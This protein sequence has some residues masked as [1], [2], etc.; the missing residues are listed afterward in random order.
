MIPI[1]KNNIEVFPI[2]VPVNNKLKSVN[3]FLVKQ[4]NSLTLID[5]GFNTDD[6]WHHLQ[7]T[8]KMN[9]YSLRDITEILL[10]HHHVDHIGLINRI[11]AEHPIPVYIHP[12]AIPKLKGDPDFIKMRLDFFKNLYQEMDCGEI[13]EKQVEY[14]YKK[15]VQAKDERIHWDFREITTNQLFGFDC[16]EIPGHA[17]DQV[18]FYHQASKGLFVGD[19]L[20]EHM[21]IN[22]FVEP[23]SN[24]NRPKTLVQQKLSLEKC[25]ALS[26]ETVYSGHGRIIEDPVP[27]FKKRI[28][29]ID[30]KA[31]SFMEIIR[32]GV[33]TASEIAQYRYKTKYDKQF[34]NVMS[35]V[36]GY[37]DYLEVHGKLNKEFVKGVWS[38]YPIGT[39]GK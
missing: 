33:S 23:D 31:D 39:Y 10:T 36:I 27:L 32:T 15:A 3:F 25:L 14:F 22:A 13:G 30:E 7:M 38:Y 16:I 2:L 4:E 6:C 28:K 29:E 9:G 11:I 18:A 35:E 19:L 21:S 37:L 34:F 17:P 5:A 26:V 24:G 12:Y 20:I 8:L 1:N